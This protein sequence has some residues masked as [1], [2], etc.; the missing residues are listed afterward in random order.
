MA[1]D[2]QSLLIFFV[3]TFFDFLG[4]GLDDDGGSIL[5]PTTK[6]DP[7]L[8]NRHAM[9]RSHMV[10]EVVPTRESIIPDTMTSRLGAVEFRA[11]VNGVKVSLEFRDI[12]K[13]PQA[14]FA[15]DFGCA[16]S[17]ALTTTRIWYALMRPTS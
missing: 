7:A 12:F 6:A 13:N 15:I 1:I 8:C 2:N 10:D 11:D 4:R 9:D 14:F 5:S 17:F 16:S 3:H